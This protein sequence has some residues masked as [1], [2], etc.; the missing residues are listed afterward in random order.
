MSKEVDIIT[1]SNLPILDSEDEEED[2]LYDLSRTLD[3]NYLDQVRSCVPLKTMRMLTPS[4]IDTILD[5]VRQG[6]SLSTA[7]ASVGVLPSTLGTYLADGKKDYESLTDE[8]FEAVDD[9]DDA[10]SEKAKFFIQVSQARGEC[11]IHLQNILI[12]KAGENG[13]EW[14]PQWLLQVME[15]ETYSLKFRT[16]KMKLDAKAQEGHSAVGRIEFVFIDG[17]DSREDEEKE[18]INNRLQELED[19]WGKATTAVNVIDAEF[20]VVDEEGGE[21]DDISGDDNDER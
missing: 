11:I 18:I 10:L 2:Y 5:H 1:T 8:D 12:D 21:D 3:E 16:E 6:M 17:F 20:L 4:K 19:K 14:I 15:P 9:P 13:K 7:G